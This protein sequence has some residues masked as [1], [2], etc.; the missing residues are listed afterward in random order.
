ML[1]DSDS[2]YV[3]LNA[4]NFKRN[5]KPKDNKILSSRLHARP[6]FINEAL[7]RLFLFLLPCGIP[8]PQAQK[9]QH[10]HFI[11]F[12]H[13]PAVLHQFVIGGIDALLIHHHPRIIQLQIG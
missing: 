7:P 13:A 2:R 6:D 11:D 3:E 8:C 10:V 1:Y 4:Q 5:G 9:A 12:L